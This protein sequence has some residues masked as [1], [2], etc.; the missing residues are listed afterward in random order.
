MAYRVLHISD[1]HLE[2]SFASMGCH[3]DLARRR[4]EG[5]RWAL[6]RAGEA[7]LTAQCDAVTIGGDLYEHDR[8]N[9]DTG[10]FL[11]RLFSSWE[12][13]VFIAPGN[14]DPHMR[15]SLYAS[16]EWS[17]NVHI[18]STPEFTPVEVAEGFMLWGLGHDQN[19]WDGDPLDLRRI[20]RPGQHIALFHGSDIGFLPDGKTPH[21]PFH[22]TS[23]KK[24]G[25][26]VALC[27]HYHSQRCDERLGLLYPGTPEPLAF[28]EEGTRGP[29]VVDINDDGSVLMTPLHLNMWNAISVQCDLSSATTSADATDLV[30][31]SAKDAA[32]GLDPALTVLRVKLDGATS[33]STTLDL[34]T[35]EHQ[36]RDAW[37]IAAVQ[38]IDNTEIAL[39][40]KAISKEPSVRGEFARF[41][42]DEIARSDDSQTAEDALRY[43]LEALSGVEV[44]LR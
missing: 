27:G 20:E 9:A 8:A 32:T 13:P 12:M 22:S 17:P 15:G 36:I 4:R 42:L 18:F 26:A 35:V 23:I 1:I 43:G 2:R 33:F 38:V 21:A 34:K 41:M 6:R 3:G 29:V 30:V 19:S 16:V 40:A 10:A 37:G 5:L 7:A 11:S 31:E 28:D 14:H 44:K 39:N 24:R 25:F